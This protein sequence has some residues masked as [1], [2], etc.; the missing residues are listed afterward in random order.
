MIEDDPGGLGREDSGGEAA[1]VV[2][3]GKRWD[4]CKS[5]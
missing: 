3:G 4:W 2:G 5:M 1:K